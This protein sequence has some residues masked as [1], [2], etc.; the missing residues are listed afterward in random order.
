MS[1]NSIL[2][3]PTF[4]T[5]KFHSQNSY[6]L[7]KDLLHQCLGNSCLLSSLHC[8]H[9]KKYC[10]LPLFH[11]VISSISCF[12]ALASR[13]SCVMPLNRLAAR[14]NN[15]RASAVKAAERKKNLSK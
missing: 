9:G 1:I 14:T 8:Y 10:H 12:C 4:L 7:I 5:C 13:F 11:L 6:M 3:I 2:S 15:T